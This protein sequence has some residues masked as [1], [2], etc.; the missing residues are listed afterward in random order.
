MCQEL[1]EAILELL[2]IFENLWKITEAQ[3]VRK[4]ANSVFLFERLGGKMTQ[5]ITDH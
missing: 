1:V 2:I 5:G 4:N 3:E